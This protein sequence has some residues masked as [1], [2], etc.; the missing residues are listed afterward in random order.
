MFPELGRGRS[1]DYL[2][3]GGDTSVRE[4]HQDN[5]TGKTDSDNAQL[6]QPS[7]MLPIQVANEI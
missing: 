4:E 7:Y 3:S 6:F 5:T 2:M 1:T